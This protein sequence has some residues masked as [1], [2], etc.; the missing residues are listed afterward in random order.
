MVVC[1][2]IEFVCMMSSVRL[3]MVSDLNPLKKRH[4]RINP[5]FFENR[6]PVLRLEIEFKASRDAA[7]DRLV[8]GGSL[9]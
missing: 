5:T 4:E 2:R 7:D 8:G 6:T 3:S 1:D 9:C